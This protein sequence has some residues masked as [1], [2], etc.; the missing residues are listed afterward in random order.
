MKFNE[1]ND[2]Q[3]FVVNYSATCKDSHETLFN[4]QKNANEILEADIVKTWDCKKKTSLLLQQSTTFDGF[5][6]IDV[7][8][9]VGK[10]TA[11]NLTVKSR[12]KAGTLEYVI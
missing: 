12:V 7:S 6:N 5:T 10:T 1:N 4:I 9:K 11:I 8:I 3:S 2:K